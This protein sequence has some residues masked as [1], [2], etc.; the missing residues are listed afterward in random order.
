MLNYCRRELTFFS[1]DDR[2]LPNNVKI[3]PYTGIVQPRSCCTLKV[4]FYFTEIK[5]FS[6]SIPIITVGNKMLILTCNGFVN[7]PKVSNYE[8][9]WYSMRFGE[10]IFDIIARTP[11]AIYIKPYISL[12]D[13]LM[14]F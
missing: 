2:E 11:T 9:I 3:L 14:L 12:I 13:F 10:K 8:K 7:Y 6:Y 5:K 1:V 4:V